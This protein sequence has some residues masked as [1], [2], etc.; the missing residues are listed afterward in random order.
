MITHLRD[1]SVRFL[2]VSPHL[3]VSTGPNA[4]HTSSFP[5]PIPRLTIELAPLLIDHSLGLSRT[6]SPSAGYDPRLTKERIDAV[7][8]V[9]EALECVTV[10]RSGAVILHRLDVPNT[11]GAFGQR[12]LPD[13]ELVSLSHIP[14]RAGLRYSPAFGVKPHK[15]R[16][17]VTACALCDVGMSCPVASNLRDTHASRLP[18][19][20]LRFGFFA[21]RRSPWSAS[22]IAP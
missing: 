2:D 9:P 1:F 12:S 14:P 4:P 3:L 15:T 17:S 20:C 8:F 11:E 13:D 10:L 6:Q 22:D 21:R 16:G 19:G 18:C 5:S 7:H